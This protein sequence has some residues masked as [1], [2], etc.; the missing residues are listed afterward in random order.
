MNLNITETGNPMN[1][2]SIYTAS[3]LDAST[4]TQPVEPVIYRP[5][6]K[7]ADRTFDYLRTPNFDYDWLNRKFFQY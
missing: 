4:K 2:P 7:R 3:Y 1:I 6:L 5:D